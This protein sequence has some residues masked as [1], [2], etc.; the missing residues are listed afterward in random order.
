MKEIF[1]QQVARKRR[2]MF[3][4][5]DYHFAVTTTS[6]KELSDDSKL[7]SMSGNYSNQWPFRRLA[8]HSSS[9]FISINMDGSI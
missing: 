4:V 3:N 9:S 7:E 2:H 8:G 5:G 6:K 1:T